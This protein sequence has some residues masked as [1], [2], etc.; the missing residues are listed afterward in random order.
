[1]TQSGTLVRAPRPPAETIDAL[2]E[3]LV[4]EVRRVLR[5]IDEEEMQANLTRSK[6]DTDHDERD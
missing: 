6:E 5:Q 4:E 3:E 2:W 1:M